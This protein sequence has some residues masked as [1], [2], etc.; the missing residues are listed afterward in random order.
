MYFFFFLQLGIP[1]LRTT[2]CF[3][4]RPTV[5]CYSRASRVL[6]VKP[7]TSRSPAGLFKTGLPSFT[8]LFKG[9][10]ALRFPRNLTA[11]D[12]LI[13]FMQGRAQLSF[14][15]WPREAG[16]LP[17]IFPDA[18][19]SFLRCRLAGAALERSLFEGLRGRL[20]PSPV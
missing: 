3:V 5:T 2:I 19:K 7:Y 9:V 13:C 18:T 10:S 20:F 16:E 4:A 11:K 17:G 12:G 14:V 15:F 6:L 8:G 1:F